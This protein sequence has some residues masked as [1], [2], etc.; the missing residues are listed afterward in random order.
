MCVISPHGAL[1]HLKAIVNQQ[2]LA[3]SHVKVLSDAAKMAPF[4]RFFFNPGAAM[5]MPRQIGVYP[6][7]HPLVNG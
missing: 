6:S 4:L 3:F 5:P 1:K 7:R 2:T